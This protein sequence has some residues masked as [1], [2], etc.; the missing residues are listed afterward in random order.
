MLKNKLEYSFNRK[1]SKKLLFGIMVLFMTLLSGCSASSQV[2][3]KWYAQNANK[4]NRVIKIDKTKMSIDNSEYTID[5]NQVGIRN[6]VKY[7]GFEVNKGQNLVVVFPNKKNTDDALI[8]LPNN[9]EDPLNGK[10]IYV[11]SKHKHPD[12]YQFMNKYVH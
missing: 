7:Y 1:T 6:E 3:G 2:Q 12:Y 9:S 10:I 4:E 11:M 5:Q 8:I